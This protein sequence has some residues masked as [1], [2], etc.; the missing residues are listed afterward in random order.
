MH[1]K[2]QYGMPTCGRGSI[3]HCGKNLGCQVAELLRYLE[4]FLGFRESTFY[5]GF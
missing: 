4:F 5:L 2:H 1:A 3:K